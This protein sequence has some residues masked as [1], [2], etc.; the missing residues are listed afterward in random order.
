MFFSARTSH[1][2][3]FWRCISRVFFQWSCGSFA[4]RET[5]P[6]SVQSL[7]AFSLREILKSFSLSLNVIPNKKSPAQY[8]FSAAF[9]FPYM[10]IVS[11]LFDQLLVTLYFNQNMD[12][13]S[14]APKGAWAERSVRVLL[15]KPQWTRFCHSR[16]PPEQSHRPFGPSTFR[17]ARLQAS[18]G[19]ALQTYLQYNK[20]LQS[21]FCCSAHW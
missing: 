8:C 10:Y 16:L 6:V 13:Q 15:P 5:D 4:A 2:S 17:C 12:A 21:F 18:I 14:C 7:Q 9:G 20:I 1:L 3:V 11:L 19:K